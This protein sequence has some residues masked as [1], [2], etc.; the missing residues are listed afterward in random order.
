[1]L[2][3]F[4][5]MQ[6]GTPAYNLPMARRVR[7][8]LDVGAL[9]SALQTLVARHESLR[10]HF[11]EVE[12]TPKQV[13]EPAD[14]FTVDVR[15]LRSA[16]AATR[17]AEAH[18]LLHE[19]AA[20]PFDLTVR[21][22]PRAVLVRLA[23]DDALLLIV[24]HHFVFDGASA[25]VLMSELASAYDALR[26]RRPI[27]L[28][29]L[30][31]QLADF[32]TWERQS[33]VDARLASSVAYWRAELDGAPSGIDLPTDFARTPGTF[34]PGGR[35]ASVLS[36]ATRDA[37]RSLA[38]KHEATTFMVLI[39]AYQA[40]LYRYSGQ[41]DLVVGA[42]VSG[43]GRPGTAGLVGFLTN[44]LALRARFDD[45]PT[46][47]S[48]LAQARGTT[49][50]ALE[51]QD[52]PYEKVVRE[53]RAGMPASEQTLFR[54]AYTH[55]DAAV[56]VPRLGDAL[57]EPL[58]ADLGVAKFDLMMSARELPQGIEIVLEY[59]S[60]LFRAETI[61]RFVTHL[62]TLIAAAAAAPETRVS[63]LPILT[64][65]ERRLM[66]ETWNATD[67]NWPKDA[68]LHDL[69]AEQARRRPD[70]IAVECGDERLTYAEL[71]RRANQLAWVLRERGVGPDV[72]VA[73]CMEKS[74]DLV[75]VLFA[76]LKAGG[77]Y[78]PM[79][80]AYPD[81]RLA[82][83]LEDSESRVVVTDTALAPRL[84]ALGAT[85]LVA[86]AVWAAADRRADA[87]PPSAHADNLCYVI[88]T[89]GSTGRPKGGLI[90]HRNVVR[91][92]I[93]D[94]LQFEFSDRDVWTVFHS[95]SFDFSVWEMYGALLYGGRAIVVPRQ[96]AQ[97][98]SEFMA[99]LAAKGVTILNQVPSAFYA[100]VQ[101]ALARPAVPLALRYIIF[102]GEA[103]Q[104]TLL[105]DW[106][107]R[108]PATTLVNMFGITETTV[109]VTF[110]VI[111][112]A[113]IANGASNIGQPI[114]TLTTYVLDEHLQL[115]PTGVTG[116]LCVGGAGVARGYLKRP[117]LTAERFVP[118]PF[119]AGERLYRSGDLGR[120]RETGDI[121]YLGRRDAQVKL[122][123]F[124]IELGEIEATLAK[125]PAVAHAAVVLRTE[126]G[127]ELVAYVVPEPEHAGTIQRLAALRARESSLPP[128]IDLPNGM[129]LFHRNRSESEFL[130]KEIFEGEG[131]LRH[132]LKIGEGD[133]V[134]DVGANVGFFTVFA[135]TQVPKTRVYAF[136]PL[137]PI[138]AALR[139]NA[140][141]Q[142]VGGRVFPCGLGSR[143]ETVEFTY[144]P[145]NTV[146]SGRFA[147]AAQETEVVRKYLT[148][149]EASA[150][151]SGSLDEML[152]H[153]LRGERY[154]C[155]I[156]RL[157]DVVREER[158][159]RIDLLKIDVEKAEW[160]VLLG[161]DDADWPKIQQVVMEVHDI[162]DRLPKVLE[163]F[164]E[165]GFE[166]FAEEEDMLVGTGLY[167]VYAWRPGQRTTSTAP[168][169]WRG[170]T[171]LRTDLERHL[172]ESLPTYMVPSAIVFLDA[173]PLT[174]SGK[175]DRRA[176]PA[177]S[178]EAAE[179]D[180]PPE[181]P[182]EEV[183][184]S[185]WRQTLQIS[186]VG[187][188]TSFF[189]L[190]GH[191]L[192][193]TR[194]V[195]ALAK[196]LRIQ[197]PIRAMFEAPTVSGIA[198]ALIAR[199]TVPGQ[200]A[201]VAQLVLKLQSQAAQA[202]GTPTALPTSPHV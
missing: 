118:H 134:F 166:C 130:F 165:H 143:D 59:R 12:G 191:S 152:S 8:P 51:H 135:G 116:E 188:T 90:E 101:E 186:R 68:T 54:V 194:V 156:R 64:A 80:P 72:L 201:K 117:E 112:D 123:G 93:N 202:A 63:R 3:L 70:A 128:Q 151:T 57:L 108:Y 1:L 56:S 13:V 144:Y 9:R 160:D 103:L 14:G 29:P 127:G 73:V 122:R 45:D 115:V 168:V 43:R 30:P 159:E 177:P 23:D 120:L 153:K 179:A 91:L 169:Q 20:R 38:T 89:S 140:E 137:P 131:Y 55:Q 81:D 171:A 18:R 66:L 129:A 119:R 102:G 75:A 60:D 182:I 105:A 172:A 6:P 32:A 149:V 132:G 196:L 15:D 175:L 25:G 141:V 87:P 96:V 94:R 7:G 190:G 35:Y 76:I 145:E 17:E 62:E 136:E 184:A 138:F 146:L 113:E 111:G 92:L 16:P 4:E 44:A 24:V 173:L 65:D 61:G 142:G 11:I 58:S 167:G 77:A 85:P 180:A 22:Y 155:S 69:F 189:E 39:A 53:L 34:G 174:S 133:V 126:R 36:A 71:D 98:P 114:P 86:D 67:A 2:W 42:A 5:Q 187:R 31:I 104:P 198:A 99:L 41:A 106:K 27:E 150:A 88:Y 121:E 162:D 78:V 46:F 147:S 200:T 79:D 185:V 199:E 163:L 183:V 158:I 74:V 154:Q 49:L 52:V 193:V 181:G 148:N 21:M 50:R 100:L 161:I 48:F 107:A 195:G 164:R 157:S 26:H 19:A 139:A 125:H 47:A 176:L 170:E 82:F 83:M 37:V 124:R 97:A 10:T 33:L 40:L 178:H 110:K 192:L 28:A 197:L 95:F 109:H 84:A